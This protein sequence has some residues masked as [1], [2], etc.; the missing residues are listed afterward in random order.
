MDERFADLAGAERIMERVNVSR[1]RPPRWPVLAVGLA[2]ALLLPLPGGNC[3]DLTAPTESEVGRPGADSGPTRVAIGV[4]VSDVTQIN[5]VAQTFSASLLVAL[6]WRDPRLAHGKPGIRRY[7]LADVWHPNWLIAN[8]VGRIFPTFPEIVEVAGDG[9]VRYRQGLTGTFAQRLDLRAFPFDRASFRLHFVVVGQQPA[10]IEFVPNEAMVAAGIPE[11]SGIAP[12]LTL[13]DWRITGYS[14]HV[15]PYPIA[16][17]VRAAGYAFEFGGERL[18][19]HYIVKVIIPLLLIVIMSWT[20]FWIDPSL[21]SSQISVAVTS[22]LTL[23][24]YRFAI[25]AEVPKLPYLT[26][27]D[28]FILASSVLVLLTLIEVI[29]TSTLAVRQ[30]VDLARRVD[31][32]SRAIFPLAYAAVIAATLLD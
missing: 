14:A 30:R 6:S 4:W 9:T 22:M 10:D 11:G 18:S 15:L 21:G 29:V 24:A 13:Q 12:A 27:L 23:I 20:A 3:A 16:P 7:R 32:Y 25:G 1:R 17:G 5:S 8:T 28:T 2:L 26:H 31:H 19:Q